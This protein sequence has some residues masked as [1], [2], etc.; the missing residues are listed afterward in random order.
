[1]ISSRASAAVRG[2][3]PHRAGGAGAD[4]RAVCHVRR[5][6]T[7]HAVAAPGPQRRHMS[8]DRGGLN[9]TGC[10]LESLDAVFYHLIECA[11]SYRGTER[12]DEMVSLA[13]RVHARAVATVQRL[14]ELKNPRPLTYVQQV[15][16]GNAV[17]V[18]N[19]GPPTAGTENPPNK[20][21]EKQR[22]EWMDRRAASA[23]IGV[24]QEL[25]TVTRSGIS[26]SPW[27][28]SLMTARMRA[29]RYRPARVSTGRLSIRFP[30]SPASSESGPADEPAPSGRGR[31]GRSRTG[32]YP[33]GQKVRQFPTRGVRM[34][35]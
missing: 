33:V 16:I 34:L 3:A 24:D 1:V 19:Q 22:N 11:Y 14:A 26:F 7:V 17:Q 4:G 10:Q 28:A 6:L 23:T 31:A 5:A 2:P 21:L 20:L 32:P 25:E 27:L 35:L 13:L 8:D 30:A 29:R 15:N 9:A 12:L 18:N